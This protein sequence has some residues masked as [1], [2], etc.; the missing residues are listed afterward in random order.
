M[1]LTSSSGP[2]LLL[3]P[4]TDAN[5]EAWDNIFELPPPDRDTPPA[6]MINDELYDMFETPALNLEIEPYQKVPVGQLI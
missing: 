4:T 2:E 1:E 5:D 3:P 6:Q